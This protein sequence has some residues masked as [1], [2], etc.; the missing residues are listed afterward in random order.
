MSGPFAVQEY[1][2]EKI[3]ND[4]SDIK[5]ICEPPPEVDE[6]DWQYEHIR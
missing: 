4:P 2:Q 3:R 5:G 1:I 6:N